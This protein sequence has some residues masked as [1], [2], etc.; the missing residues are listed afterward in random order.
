[1][2][3][4]PHLVLD[5]EA[6]DRNLV[7]MAGA[8]ASAGVALR[9]HVKGH[10]CSWIARRQVA[11]GAVGVAAATLD[12][13]AAMVDGGVSDVLLTSV[14][15]PQRLEDATALGR[16]AGRLTLVVH[17]PEL[18]RALGAAASG[19]AV[20]VLLDLDVGQRRG[21]ARP[22]ADA[23]AVA[24]AAQEADGVE[25]AGVQ[26]YEGH[27][28]AI[29]DSATRGAASR[30]A[31]DTLAAAVAGL[32]AAGHAVPWVT[33]AG[34]GTAGFAAAH[35]VV[36]EVQPGSYALMDAAYREVDGVAFAQAVHVAASVIAVL[37][38]GDAI[39]DAGTKALS[40]DLGPPRVASPAGA[41]YVPAGDEHGR[42]T[43]ADGLQA[44]DVV[45]LVPSHADTT[46]DL[47]DAFWLHDGTH[48]VVD[49]RSRTRRPAAAAG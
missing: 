34:T 44:G 47:H 30:A 13:A 9:P 33:T 20:D 18:A 22:G 6:L 7:A 31:M 41:A 3:A 8:T 46:V 49:A 23:L 24:A 21:G 43:G 12:E 32:R 40:T 27:L 35:P 37:P 10:K 26:G 39:V 19:T 48:L 42:V 2:P 25:L 16:R 28:Q 1:M 36:T 17:T 15:P 45:L 38:D 29:A 11:A 4:T 14:L 5:L